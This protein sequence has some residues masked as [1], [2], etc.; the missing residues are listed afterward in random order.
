MKNKLIIL[1]FL[2]AI[3]FSSCLK[4]ELA[5]DVIE[6]PVLALFENVNGTA[7]SELTMVATF[8]ELDKSGILDQ[9]IGIDSIAIAG[10]TVEV[11]INESTLLGSAT[12]DSSGKATFVKSFSDL[13]GASR[14]EWVGN[15]D[16]TPFRIYNNF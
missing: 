16:N 7:E 13:D 11:Y 5:F 2:F 9:N 8:Y 3:S 15:Y 12:T 6:S 1:S 4:D 10:M 14:L